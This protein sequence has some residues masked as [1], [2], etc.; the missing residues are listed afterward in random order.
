MKRR[1]F[2]FALLF[3]A[4]SFA[5]AVAADFLGMTGLEEFLAGVNEE[6]PIIML[7]YSEG[8]EEEAA[9]TAE[10]AERIAAII[11]A[12]EQITVSGGSDIEVTDWYPLLTLTRADGAEIS[13]RFNG[14]RLVHDGGIAVLENDDLFWRLARQGCLEA[15]E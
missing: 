9:F 14:H 10:E 6:N 4:L 1:G 15:Q 5:Y 7:C 3:T 11:S 2:L 12:L 8:T 13:I